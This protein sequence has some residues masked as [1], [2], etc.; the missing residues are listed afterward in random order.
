MRREIK[1]M[2][3]AKAVAINTIPLWS[4][5]VM[6]EI[7]GDCPGSRVVEFESMMS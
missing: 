4:V 7:G 2:V 1:A 6:I 5:A 3:S